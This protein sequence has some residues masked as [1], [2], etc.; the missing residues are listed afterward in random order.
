MFWYRKDYI[1]IYIYAYFAK[2]SIK[3]EKKR[4]GFSW[5]SFYSNRDRMLFYWRVGFGLDREPDPD[6]DNLN[7]VNLSVHLAWG[8]FII[9][10]GERMASP[11]WGGVGVRFCSPGPP[12]LP[13]FPL[14]YHFSPHFIKL[15]ER[16]IW[17]KRIG[18]MVVKPTPPPEY[19]PAPSLLFGYHSREHGGLGKLRLAKS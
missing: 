12:I 17:H 2:I 11:I 6:P 15:L 7:P 8:V 3:F 13:Q 18:K 4:S 10:N 14:Y 5:T 9:Q 19:A 1:H 16:G